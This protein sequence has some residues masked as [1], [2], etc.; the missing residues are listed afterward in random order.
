MQWCS[1]LL[2]L[3]LT[4]DTRVVFDNTVSGKVSLRA[5][6]ISSSPYSLTKVNVTLF[7]S[8]NPSNWGIGLA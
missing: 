1:A 5:W 6:R 3:G 7:S 8:L 2:R 4:L